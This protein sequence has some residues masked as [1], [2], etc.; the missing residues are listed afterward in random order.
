[1]KNRSSFLLII[2]FSFFLSSCKFSCSVG[3]NDDS[4]SA[5]VVKEG[6][7]LYNNI[8]LNTNH[9]KVSK[10]YLLLDNGER[11]PDDNFVSFNGPVKMQMYIDS[12]WV[13][14]NGKVM[15]GASEKITTEHGV[16]LV[17]KQDLFQE[18]PD[19][20]PAADSKSLYLTATLEVKKNTPPV[21]I[22]VSFRIWDKN[23]DGY[24]EGNYKLFSK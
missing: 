18:Y 2:I 10:A 1:M 23:G 16:V 6:A 12:G 7:R 8:E 5:A 20:I 24:I 3:E 15:L 19:G 21:S 13:E 22:T 4:K 11:V 9:V 17:D 14:K